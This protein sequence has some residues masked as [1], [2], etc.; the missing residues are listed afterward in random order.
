MKTFMSAQS[1]CP[2]STRGRIG[3]GPWMGQREGPL[4][5]Q[6]GSVS[7]QTQPHADL[8][9][10]SITLSIG[11]WRG[12]EPEEPVN[13][14]EQE[15]PKASEQIVGH[16]MGGACG[17]WGGCPRCHL[18]RQ[19]VR[20]TAASLEATPTSCQLVVVPVGILVSETPGQRPP[21]HRSLRTGTCIVKFWWK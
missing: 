3:K 21:Q 18:G 14:L 2:L 15:S 4:H 20:A 10:W 11:G 9:E 16:P 12:Q 19:E 7:L 1:Q 8:R 17:R 13:V 6:E 5:T